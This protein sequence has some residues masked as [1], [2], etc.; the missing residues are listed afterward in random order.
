MKLQWIIYAGL[1]IK[2]LVTPSSD[3]TPLDFILTLVY[4]NVTMKLY[5]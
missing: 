4:W 1:E 5:N 2:L 3:F